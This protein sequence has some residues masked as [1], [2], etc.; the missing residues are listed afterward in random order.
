[1]TGLLARVSRWLVH[2]EPLWLVTGAGAVLDVA[3]YVVPAVPDSW[4]GWVNA[5]VVL[6]GVLSGRAMVS[7]VKASGGT[8][9]RG[10]PPGW[11]PVSETAT[12]ATGGPT[13]V[14]TIPPTTGDP[15]A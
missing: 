12:G 15:T 1:M 2:R 14:R 5:V 7:P 13:N 6:L 3:S 8:I 9:P 4:H 11:D 10:T